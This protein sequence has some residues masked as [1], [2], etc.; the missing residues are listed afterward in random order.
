MKAVKKIASVALPV[1]AAFIPGVGPALSAALVGGAGVLGSKIGGASWG[2]ALKHGALSGLTA[3]IAPIAGN[4]FASFAPETA[5][6]LGINGGYNTI[7][8]QGAGALSG[9]GGAA[10]SAAGALNTGAALGDIANTTG[11]FS[12]ADAGGALGDIGS[13]TGGFSAADSAMGAGGNDGFLSGALSKF[14]ND[15][16]KSAALLMTATNALRGGGVNGEQTQA[17]ILAQQQAKQAQDAAFSKQTIDML[18][19]AQ[20]G[21]APTVPSVS[22]YYTYGTRPEAAFFT[23]AKPITYGNGALNG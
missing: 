7:F 8:G 16:F 6:A 19:S 2:D 14:K 17:Q 5:G 3:G 4:A 20:T 21:R 23:P 22:D 15:P 1:A 9:M 18:N 13:T 11:G 12:A 10:G